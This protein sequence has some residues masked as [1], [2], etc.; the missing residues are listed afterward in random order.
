MSRDWATIA[1]KFGRAP[2]PLKLRQLN[3]TETL[4]TPRYGGDILP[5]CRWL[6]GVFLLLRRPIMGTSST[7]A[8]DLLPKGTPTSA[9]PS[10]ANLPSGPSN[11]PPGLSYGPSSLGDAGTGPASTPR[12][13]RR[14]CRPIRLRMRQ[15][16]ICLSSILPALPLMNCP[17]PA[18]ARGQRF[19]ISGSPIKM[20]LYRLPAPNRTAPAPHRPA[21]TKSRPGNPALRLRLSNRQRPLRPHRRQNQCP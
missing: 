6:S 1:S 2:F 8:T 5:A 9:T 20:N 18:P 17:Q 11:L 15:S 19:I 13:L 3:P 14:P 21:A 10:G 7:T 12:P 16:S 4:V